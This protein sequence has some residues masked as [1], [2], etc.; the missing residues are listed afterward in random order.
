MILVLANVVL[1]A[2][3]I[4]YGLKQ[5]RIKKAAISGAAGQQEISTEVPEHVAQLFT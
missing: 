4:Y 3:N 2:V 5:R 1:L